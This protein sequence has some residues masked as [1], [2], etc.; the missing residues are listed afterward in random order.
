MLPKGCS[1]SKEMLQAHSSQK[2]GTCSALSPKGGCW[3]GCKRKSSFQGAALEFPSVEEH[4]ALQGQGGKPGSSMQVVKILPEAR[5]AVWRTPGWVKAP[6][7]SRGAEGFP[8]GEMRAL[9]VLLLVSFPAPKLLLS[10]T[11]LKSTVLLVWTVVGVSSPNRRP[12]LFAR[13]K[14]KKCFPYICQL[15][16]FTQMSGRDC[17]MEKTSE[18]KISLAIPMSLT[19]LAP[20]KDKFSNEA[21]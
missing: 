16:T 10:Y 1:T 13:Q 4:W 7:G 21:I 3:H 8:C 17:Q 19:Y 12:Y 9:S 14:E 2:T 6:R 5:A 20:L 11:T 15:C 18:I